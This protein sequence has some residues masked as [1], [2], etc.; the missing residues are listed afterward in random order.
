MLSNQNPRANI[1]NMGRSDVV[2]VVDVHV[3]SAAEQANV[4]LGR[5]YLEAFFQFFVD[6]GQAVALIAEYDNRPAGYCIGA[7]YGYRSAMLRNLAVPALI[8]LLPQPALWKMAAVAALEPVRRLRTEDRSGDGATLTYALVGIAVRPE[9]RGAGIA[10]DLVQE[11]RQRVRQRLE[12]TV[13]RLSVHPDN[14]RAISF[15]EREGWRRSASEGSGASY[16]LELPV[17]DRS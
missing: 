9:M 14:H 11:F 16:W 15:Y 8:G 3:R 7:P 2:S 17:F 12:S 4:R 1:R 5:S 10:E 13:M 6:S